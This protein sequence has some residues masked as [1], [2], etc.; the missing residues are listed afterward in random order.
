[1]AYNAIVKIARNELFLKLVIN[2]KTKVMEKTK[3][4]Q[5]EKVIKGLEFSKSENMGFEDDSTII[6]FQD[7]DKYGRPYQMEM[8]MNFNEDEFGQVYKPMRD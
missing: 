4:T 7:V 6:M 3:M 1:M 5:E 8:R 2:Q